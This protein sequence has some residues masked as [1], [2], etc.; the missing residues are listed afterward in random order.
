[1]VSC[2]GQPSSLG[3]LCFLSLHSLAFFLLPILVAPLLFAPLA[4]RPLLCAF[5]LLLCAVGSV[6]FGPLLCPFLGSFLLLLHVLW[7][8]QS[9][10]LS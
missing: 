7:R 4:L 10:N 8:V 3:G 2:G 9:N 5:C 1:M 6:P